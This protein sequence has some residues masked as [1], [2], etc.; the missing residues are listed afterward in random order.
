[1]DQTIIDG[2]RDGGMVSFHLAETG[3]AYLMSTKPVQSVD[4]VRKLRAWIPDGDPIAAEL[5]KSFGV[6]PIPL[7]LVDVLPGLQTGLIDAVAAPPVVALALQWHNQ[8]EYLLDVPLIYVYSAMA[9]DE[10]SFA[11]MA[12]E[13][14]RLVQASMDDVFEQIDRENRTDNQKAFDALLSQGI[15]VVKPGPDELAGWQDRARKSID[16]LVRSGEISAGVVETLDGHL[17]S[18]RALPAGNSD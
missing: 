8:L 15:K 7:H 6:S 11:G 14:Q 2:L 16:D 10:R 17:R 18:F 5:L 4:D 1:M 13:D 12:E 3:F 9:M